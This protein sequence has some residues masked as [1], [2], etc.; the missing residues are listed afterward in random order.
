[1]SNGT[2]NFFGRLCQLTKRA[3][4]VSHTNLLWGRRLHALGKRSFV[5]LRGVTI[6]NPSAVAVGARV[7]IEKHS[8]LADLYPSIGTNPKIIIGDGCVIH[9][10]FQCNAAESVWIGKNVL[11]A[12]NVLI[13]D[14][15]HVVEPGHTP[16]TKNRK[17]ITKPVCIKDNCWLGHNCVILKGVTINSHCIIGANSVVTHDIPSCS[18]AAG[19][20]AQVI[21]K[22]HGLDKVGADS[23]ELSETD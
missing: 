7:I 18:V 13:T 11:I 15:D 9:S 4:R 8:T 17:L 20:P 3:W 19:N 14:S 1:M 6:I 21:K 2:N 12:S 22:L 10:N 5:S 23:R 16:V